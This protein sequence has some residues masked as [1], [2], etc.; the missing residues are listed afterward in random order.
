MKKQLVAVFLMA[1]FLVVAFTIGDTVQAAGPNYETVKD[2][3]AR[4]RSG[5]QVK[6]NANDKLGVPTDPKAGVAYQLR[7][8]EIDTSTGALTT[9]NNGV[10]RFY[11]PAK[12]THND[13][14]V[15]GNNELA[16]YAGS[17]YDIALDASREGFSTYVVIHDSSAPT[18]YEFR[19]DLPGGTKLSEDGNGGIKILN[20]ANETVG[21][22]AP[23][24]AVD[25]NGV[26]RQTSFKL[27][28]GVIVQ[29]I[30]HKG[31]TY[32]VVADPNV[33][34]GWGVYVRYD[35]TEG[36]SDTVAEA[37]DLIEA[38]TAANCTL[39]AAA[40]AAVLTGTSSGA[41][42]AAGVVVASAYCY[43]AGEIE[44]D[45]LDALEE[46]EDDLPTISWLIPSD[47]TL[48]LRFSYLGFLANRVEVEDCGS[49][50]RRYWER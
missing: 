15:I 3:I 17:S 47:C 30:T 45:A 35:L 4:H 11:M 42:A 24:W 7:S 44:E 41:L 50:S 28:N 48:Q 32:P 23:P 12:N 8:M 5:D 21:I 43:N 10:A 19:L 40:I 26:M 20:Q 38:S 18:D 33:S 34:F 37:E 46:V 6:L 14:R 2:I 31:A 39:G 49:Y 1:T 9:R 22:I 16:V 36:V 25:S 27:R 13:K 29:T